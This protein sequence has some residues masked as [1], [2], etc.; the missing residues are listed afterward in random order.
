MGVGAVNAV[1]GIKRINAA[2]IAQYG[3][4]GS[5]LDKIQGKLQG[6]TE[7]QPIP[8]DVL[9]DMKTL[10]S[11][12]EAEP[13]QVYNDSLNSLNNRTGAQFKPAF[14][15]PGS[16]KSTGKSGTVRARD[17]DGKLHEAPAGTPL[18]AGWK[19]E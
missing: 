16:A 14:A 8:A 7:G 18:P 5:L 2:E 6:W 9:K 11:T 4:A 1:N 19:L 13:Y 17:T 12:L 15:P 10:H 3:T